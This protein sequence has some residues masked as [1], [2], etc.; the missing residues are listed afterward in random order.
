MPTI[1]NLSV[2]PF[3][4][5]RK[6]CKV[7]FNNVDGVGQTLNKFKVPIVF[8]FWKYF[9]IWKVFNLVP[10]WWIQTNYVFYSQLM[11]RCDLMTLIQKNFIASL[12]LFKLQPDISGWRFC[13]I[14]YNNGFLRVKK[15]FKLLDEIASP[16]KNLLSFY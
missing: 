7:Y 13:T 10:K 14:F 4:T 8:R 9:V 12:D 11:P 1:M 3:P 5:P 6:K 15:R 16:Q 2:S